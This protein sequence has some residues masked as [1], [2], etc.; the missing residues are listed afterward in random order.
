MNLNESIVEDAALTWFA[1]LGYA[2]GHGPQIA[3]GELLAERGS[4]GEVVLVGRLR[5]A[6]RRLYPAIPMEAR[7]EAL[8]KVLRVAT[9]SLLQTNRAFHRMLRDGVD[10]EYPRPD[11]SI[12]GDKAR[13]V[14]FAD[15]G[16]NDWFVVRW[17]SRTA[18]RI[19]IRNLRLTGQ[20][21]R[22][23]KAGATPCR[24]AP[25]LLQHMVDEL[26]PASQDH[27]LSSSLFDMAV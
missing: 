2:L 21:R 17:N 27:S 23:E 6:I 22:P 11:G 3:P 14:D 24:T 19:T 12:K 7:D 16:A 10:V 15:V 9:P 8:R 1:E 25:L 4:F 13:L 5:E 18:A 20:I 26:L